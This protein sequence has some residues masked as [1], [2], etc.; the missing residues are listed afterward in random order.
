MRLADL[1]TG[2]KS[3]TDG[4]KMHQNMVQNATVRNDGGHRQL[5]GSDTGADHSRGKW[6]QKAAER[7]KSD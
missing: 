3:I 1:F 7:Y 6:C 4:T 2:E 5:P